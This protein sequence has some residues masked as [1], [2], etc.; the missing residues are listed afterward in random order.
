[1]VVELAAVRLLAPWFGAST[2]VWTNVI[3]VI[4]F[5]LALGYLLG[6]RLSNHRRPGVVL[7]FTSLLAAGWVG[8]TPAAAGQVCALFL[9]TGVALHEATGLLVWGSLAT[10]LVVF[11]PAALLL[12]SI[13]PLGVELVQRASGARAGTAGGRVL[14]ASTLG[15]LVGVFGTTHVFVPEWGLETTFRVCALALALVGV[16]L[17]VR[18]RA[19]RP[20]V[21]GAAFVAIA[22]AGFGEPRRPALRDGV[23]VL[24][25]RESPY[26]SVRVVEEERADV[27]FRQLQVNEGFDSFQSVWRAEPG[28]FGEGYYYDLFA[29]PPH[30]DPRER[31]DTLL[32]GLGAGSAWRVLAGTVPNGTA[33]S[34]L[35]LEI[36]PVVVELGR[37][38][39][40][41]PVDGP[42]RRVLGGGDGRAVLGALAPEDRFDYAVIDAYAHQVEIPA[43]LVSREFFR[44]I[45][46]RLEPGGWLGANVGGFG[47]DDPVVRAVGATIASAFEQRV[48]ALRVPNSRNYVLFARQGAEPPAP[49]WPERADWLAA[50]T[51]AAD[52]AWMAA[53]LELAGAWRWLDESSGVV[54]TD[55]KNPIERL[56]ARSIAEARER[57]STLP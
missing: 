30:L 56:Q 39:C 7:G 34:L 28:L 49:P 10:T 4:L 36:D 33:L 1:M 13:G 41:L 2:P 9:P 32:V 19:A 35:G 57:R 53:P 11:L 37:R 21:L 29:L 47:F 50:G 23:T 46:E 14:G 16:G 18:E 48:L 51:P 15:S 6:A 12:G 5:G 20:A 17:F 24:A 40:D 25:E 45:R 42:D 44:A 8:A 31:W 27:L 26:Q 38:F 43:H 54:L 3:G 52:V 22:T 55:D